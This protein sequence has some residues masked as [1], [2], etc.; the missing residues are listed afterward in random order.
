MAI[1]YLKGYSLRRAA[2][3]F[4]IPK[5][6]IKFV[7]RNENHGPMWVD[8]RSGEMLPANVIKEPFVDWK[9]RLK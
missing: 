8:S 1:K 5:G 3:Y 4:G 2:K 7:G 6:A 9:L